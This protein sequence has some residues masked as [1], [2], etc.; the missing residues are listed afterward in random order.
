[1]IGSNY[2]YGGMDPSG[3]LETSATT[4]VPFLALTKGDKMCITVFALMLYTG[5]TVFDQ[6][7]TQSELLLMYQIS[8]QAFFYREPFVLTEWTQMYI[9]I[10]IRVIHLLSRIS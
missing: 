4:I 9:F 5:V 8:T 7:L 3:P 1:M 6:I 2:F 10:T